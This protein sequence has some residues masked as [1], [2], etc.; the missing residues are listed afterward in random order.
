MLYQEGTKAQREE[1]ICP[2]T[3]TVS[4][5]A[6]ISTATLPWVPN[7]IP[8]HS[9]TLLRALLPWIDESRQEPRSKLD[10]R[11]AQLTPINLFNAETLGSQV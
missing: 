6:D 10:S 9:V 11:W 8:H 7:Y 2:N 4:A 3:T 5:R 1:A